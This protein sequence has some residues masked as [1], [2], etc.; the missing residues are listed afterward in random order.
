MHSHQTLLYWPFLSDDLGKGVN[1]LTAARSACFT[2]SCSTSCATA[3]GG[4]H[5]SG[6]PPWSCSVSGRFCRE[7]EAWLRP[8]LG[9]DCPPVPSPEPEPLGGHR[10]LGRRSRSQQGR[11]LVLAQERRHVHRGMEAGH[12]RAAVQSAPPMAC[13]FP[14]PE[15]PTHPALARRGSDSSRAPRPMASRRSLSCQPPAAPVAAGLWPLQGRADCPGFGVGTQGPGSAGGIG[16]LGAGAEPLGA[17]AGLPPGS[18]NRGAQVCPACWEASSS[19]SAATGKRMAPNGVGLAEG[20]RPGEGTRAGLLKWLGVYTREIWT[21]RQTCTEGG[22]CEETRE[23]AAA[24]QPSREALPGPPVP[25]AGGAS[26]EASTGP[27]P[28]ESRLVSCSL[29][30][31]FTALRATRLY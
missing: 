15:R 25:A 20:T 24:C 19:A 22:S 30:S 29:G 18:S 7:Q 6:Q 16:R 1:A 4:G 13:C 8:P 3:A 12:H 5:R 10:H 26:A 28:S 31:S 11:T 23:K 21:H 14:L 2:H 27:P 17:R 9:S